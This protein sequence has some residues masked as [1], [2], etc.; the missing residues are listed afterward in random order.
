MT[1]KLSP[2]L[3]FAAL[4]RLAAERILIL[5]GAM[6]TQIQ[7]LGLAENFVGDDAMTVILGDNIF[8]S[9]LKK[10]LDNYPGAGAQILLKQV[11]DPGRFGV[12]EVEGQKIVNIEDAK[13]E[14]HDQSS[15][16]QKMLGN[17]ESK[18]TFDK[19]GVVPTDEGN[20]ES[21]EELVEVN[22]IKDGDVTTNGTSMPEHSEKEDSE[23][24]LEE[25]SWL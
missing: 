9:P 3:A 18:E 14:Q 21:H 2:S 11:D 13:D 10:A 24:I 1:G 22:K 16:S 20:S 12:A 4:N 23:S 19:N 7:A 5:D 17:D 6:G 15:L 25:P 8:H